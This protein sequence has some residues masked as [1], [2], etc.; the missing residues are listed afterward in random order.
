[1]FQDKKNQAAE[2]PVDSISRDSAE[3]RK[4]GRKEGNPEGRKEKR[5]EKRK[6]GRTFEQPHVLTACTRF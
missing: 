3:E 5:K 4:E 6:E 2:I 1:M